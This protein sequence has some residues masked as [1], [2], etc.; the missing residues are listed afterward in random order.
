MTPQEFDERLRAAKSTS[1]GPFDI[2]VFKRYKDET[3]YWE[4]LE[5][6]N[7][8]E[9][10]LEYTE[11]GRPC[12]FRISVWMF[13]HFLGLWLSEC[14]RVRSGEKLTREVYGQ[15]GTE[16]LMRG[17]L[18]DQGW[19]WRAAIRGYWDEFQLE[20]KREHLDFNSLLAKFH[21]TIVRESSVYPGFVSSTLI[22]PVALDLTKLG[23][24]E[25]RWKEGR[26][27]W[28]THK[29][30]RCEWAHQDFE[31]LE[32]PVADHKDFFQDQLRLMYGAKGDLDDPEL[33]RLERVIASGLKS[34]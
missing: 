32:I 19:L 18:G 21:K 4:V 20:V 27:V 26:M 22:Y 33:K 15:A 11:D 2:D 8:R 6:L 30:I 7:N 34:L 3:R 16:T 31:I 24:R 28:D 13:I 1:G 12:L 5:E 25:R 14:Y 9:V 10:S 29:I 23:Y 17:F